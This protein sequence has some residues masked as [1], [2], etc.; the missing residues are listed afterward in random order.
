MQ[1]IRFGIIGSGFGARVMLPCINFID[2]F[3]VTRIANTQGISNKHIDFNNIKICKVDEIFNKSDF[4]IICIET[5]PVSHYKLINLA[6]K[7]KIKIICEKPFVLKENEAIDL[8]KQTEEKKIFACI[9]HQLRFHP[10][11][12]AIKKIISEGDLGSIRHIEINHHSS[13]NYNVLNYN[14]WWYNKSYGGGQLNALGSHFIDLI[15]FL[16]GDIKKVYARLKSFYHTDNDDIAENYCSLFLELNDGI[17]CSIITSSATNSDFGL[18]LSI[19]GS[20]KKVILSKFNQLLLFE[21]DKYQKILNISKKDILLDKKIIGVNSWRTSLVYHLQH[22]KD[23]FD[24]NY[25]YDG[26]NFRDG[27]KVLN[28]INAAKL[29]N[30]LDQG[31]QINNKNL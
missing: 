6:I 30:K 12:L 29:S 24:N 22:L 26:C 7:N 18:D 13:L 1:E 20:K 23:V 31:I 27:L 17:T 28:V 10:N 16:F 14:N 21:N 19:S 5:P 8:I 4:D 15:L 11:I 25:D 2:N 3:K 9:N